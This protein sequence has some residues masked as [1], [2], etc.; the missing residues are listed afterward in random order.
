MKVV[1]FVNLF[2]CTSQLL[3]YGFQSVVYRHYHYQ[4]DLSLNT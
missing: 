4:I 2:D 3:V 1:S